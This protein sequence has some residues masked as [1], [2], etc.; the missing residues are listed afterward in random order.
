MIYEPMPMHIHTCHQPGGSMEGHIYNASRL[1]MR[2]I[3]FTDHDT[4]TGEK[5]NQVK[6][7]GGQTALASYVS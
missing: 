1:G 3:R 2:Y 6:G 5:K 4:R 7:F